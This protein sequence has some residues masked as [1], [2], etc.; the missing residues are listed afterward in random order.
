MTPRGAL[1]A[2]MALALPLLV[3]SSGGGRAESAPTGAAPTGAAPA[4]P[5]VPLQELLAV[6]TRAG[7]GPARVGVEAVYAPPLLFSVTGVEAP[8]GEVVVFFLQESVHAGGLPPSAPEV[9]LV[10]DDA[11]QYAP[12]EAEVL[13][14]DVHHRTTRLGFPK[15]V[16][17]EATSRLSLVVPMG[18]GTVTGA[19][20]FTWEFPL[21]LPDGS[22]IGVEAG[23]EGGDDE[24]DNISLQTVQTGRRTSVGQ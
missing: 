8:A 19:N 22:V 13:L 2:L 18:D 20:V 5:V 3:A 23:V 11:A 7:V 21:E 9:Y 6:L 17:D 1:V 16:V 12:E 10:V 24:I 14:D 4:T 15:S